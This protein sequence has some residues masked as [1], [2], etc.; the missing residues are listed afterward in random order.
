MRRAP[1]WSR[2]LVRSSSAHP[3]AAG[4]VM[5][6]ARAGPWAA[7]QP[8]APSVSNASS[9]C[10]P[11]AV[12]RRPSSWASARTARTMAWLPSLRPMSASNEGSSLR[13][14]AGSRWTVAREDRPTSNS[15]A[16]RAVSM[17][18]TIPASRR[19]P[20]ERLTSTSARHPASAQAR[21]ACLFHERAP[22][23]GD[24]PEASAGPGAASPPIGYDSLQLD[25][26][27]VSTRRRTRIRMRFPVAPAERAVYDR[28]RA[29]GRGIEFA[30]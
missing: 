9:S 3:S 24:A 30:F 17:R 12:T 5:A 19:S 27:I 2:A 1:S 16:E 22:A 11:P 21:A 20:S 23:S 7:S 25:G 18:R 14:S 8:R 13:S 4:A 28:A 26:T 10:T 6:W 29:A 15:S